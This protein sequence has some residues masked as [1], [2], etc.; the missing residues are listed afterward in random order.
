[1]GRGQSWRLRAELGEGALDE[2]VA[3]VRSQDV[4]A[5]DWPLPQDVVVTHDGNTLFAYAT[6]EASIRLAR[7]EVE[8]LPHQAA[9]LVSHWDEQLEEWVQVDPPVSGPAK[10][11]E[12]ANE[13]A[14]N[15]V[16]TRTMVASA[17]RLVRAERQTG[18]LR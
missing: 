8:A 3:Q 13:R 6:S 18:Q 11:R 16:E 14:A 1:M 2:A 15:S 9:I 4:D 17:G 5:A 12:K 7:K 10:R